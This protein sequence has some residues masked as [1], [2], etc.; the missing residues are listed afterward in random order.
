MFR[1]LVLLLLLRPLVDLRFLIELK[2][3]FTTLALKQMLIESIQ[4]WSWIRGDHSQ[5]T[6]NIETLIIAF[7]QFVY[8]NTK[9]KRLQLILDNLG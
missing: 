9:I 7:N 5:P 1:T 2:K 8:N 3:Y 4:G 6:V